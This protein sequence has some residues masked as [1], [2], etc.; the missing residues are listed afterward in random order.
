MQG[1]LNLGKDVVDT[2]KYYLQENNF[3]N[4][5][6]SMTYS[7][8]SG[9]ASS[10]YIAYLCHKVKFCEKKYKK[11]VNEYVTSMTKTIESI[12]HRTTDQKLN[13]EEKSPN[14]EG[15]L[16]KCLKEI[17]TLLHSADAKIFDDN[18]V[19]VW[20]DIIKK[21]CAY[22]Q[23]A[24]V[25]YVSEKFKRDDNKKKKLTQKLIIATVVIEAKFQN[26]LCI[27]YKICM[28]SYECTKALN[29]L[30]EQFKS[31]PEDK[32]RNFVKSF[33]K[34]LGDTKFYSFLSEVT[35][36]E[37]QVILN[38]MAFSENIPTKGVI[39]SIH[40]TIQGRMQ[41]IDTNMFEIKGWDIELFYAILSDMD[42]FYS[43]HRADP[44]YSFL[45]NFFDWNRTGSRLNVYLREAMKDITY[46]VSSQSDS[47]V[48]KLT[49]EIKVFLELTVDP[50]K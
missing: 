44:L 7:S 21:I 17:K 34:T 35:S 24:A 43:K 18:A 20:T 46:K 8:E 41:A 11:F 13:Y 28:K 49:N 4:N 29:T 42:Y 15:Y 3:L 40:K 30:M 23:D 26:I 16:K 33:Y 5:R 1:S 6:R 27:D 47:I 25:V 12:I 38:D 48:I 50:E 31:M 14:F 39:L 22:F 10:T 37:F 36:H 9:D 2:I 32:V 19:M 45:N